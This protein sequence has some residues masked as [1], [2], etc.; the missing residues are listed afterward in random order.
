MVGDDITDPENAPETGLSDGEI[1]SVTFP[2]SSPTIPKPEPD[3]D[4]TFKTVKIDYSVIDLPTPRKTTSIRRGGQ[5]TRLVRL[6]ATIMGD[7]TPQPVAE[8]APVPKPVAAPQPVND[9]VTQALNKLAKSV[10]TLGLT[11]QEK[12]QQTSAIAVAVEKQHSILPKLEAVQKHL[13]QS[14]KVE[15]ANQRLFDA[16]HQELKGYKDQFLFDAL[17]KPIIRDLLSLYDDLNGQSSHLE[18][19]LAEHVEETSSEA[20][21]EIKSA[22]NNLSNTVFF[23]IEVLNRLEV[24]TLESND[25]TLDHKNHKVV[26]VQT[27]ADP[28]EKNQIAKVTRPGF[29]WKDRVLR[30]TEVIIKKYQETKP[31]PAEQNQLF[32][33]LQP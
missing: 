10:A 24:T 4:A 9:E 16:M 28:E 23:L 33:N 15:T 1:I 21:N 12:I 29:I 19:F 2:Y 27:T 14:H 22:Q 18:K 30:P 6:E 5:R 3:R 26:G 20:L 25:E 17:Q 32:P 11:V 31:V 13:D 7:P 8:I